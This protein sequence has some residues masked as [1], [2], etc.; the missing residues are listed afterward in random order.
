MGSSEFENNDESNQENDY[1]PNNKISG[2]YISQGN[3]FPEEETSNF[4]GTRLK[5]NNFE[6]S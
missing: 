4:E 1:S 2:N 3:D 6:E 5:V